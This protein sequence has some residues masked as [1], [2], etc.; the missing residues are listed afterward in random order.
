[1]VFVKGIAIYFDTAKILLFGEVDKY[2]V[3]KKC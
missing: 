2:K 1:M 3:L